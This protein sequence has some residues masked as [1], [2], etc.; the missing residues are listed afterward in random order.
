MNRDNIY[1]SI[2]VRYTDDYKIRALMITDGWNGVDY[3]WWRIVL[4]PPHP[5]IQFTI[6]GNWLHE[7]NYSLPYLKAGC[8]IFSGE[9]DNWL[10]IIAFPSS[11]LSFS[12]DSDYTLS[13]VSA[14]NRLFF[15]NISIIV[16]KFVLKRPLNCF[17]FQYINK[18]R[19][20]T[21]IWHCSS[22]EKYPKD[23]IEKLC[24]FFHLMY[25]S[26]LTMIHLLLPTTY[27]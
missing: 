7:C 14:W 10:Y 11:I 1:R 26:T 15:L 3:L 20:R 24:Y 22:L 17:R 25:W 23:D 19:K 6:I 16:N 13:Q 4:P 21:G 9:T 12:S 2:S 8:H 27:D 5:F 18:N